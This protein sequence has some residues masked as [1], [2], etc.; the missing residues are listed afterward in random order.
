MYK[1]LKC[2]K[3][4][5]FK[6]RIIRNS[7]VYSYNTRSND[8]FRPPRERLDLC[9]KSFFVKGLTL[10]NLL[11]DEYKSSVN[12]YIFKRNFKSMLLDYTFPML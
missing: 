2:G 8:L 5:E 6:K 12:V 11:D 10:W 9:R 4:P 7:D 3:F 1:C